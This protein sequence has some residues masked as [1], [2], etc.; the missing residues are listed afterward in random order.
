MDSNKRED[1]PRE[2]ETC[3]KKA[4]IKSLSSGG[5]VLIPGVNSPLWM[6]W[7]DRVNH[8]F[9]LIDTESLS[10]SG[11]HELH[12]IT[13]APVDPLLILKYNSEYEKCMEDNNN[14]LQKDN[15]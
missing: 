11:P 1:I 7:M 6:Q 9:I 2:C 4:L 3:S 5:D 13:P 8:S 14:D 15:T 10:I 12:E